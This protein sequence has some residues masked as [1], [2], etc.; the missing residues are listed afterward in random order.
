MPE[1]T[2]ELGKQVINAIEDLGKALGYYVHSEFPVEQRA[3]PPAVDVAWF[4]DEVEQKYPLMIFEVESLASNAMANNP[5]RVFGQ[6]SKEFERPL[7]FFHLVIKSGK[8][9]TR[10]ENLQR[11]FGAHNYRIYRLDD[12]FATSF[13]KDVL[14]QHRRIRRDIDLLITM[15]VLFDYDCLPADKEAILLHAIDL[16]LYGSHLS[17]L[18]WLSQKYSGA[19]KLF[20]NH[21]RR[22]TSRKIPKRLD[23]GY[24]SWLG[25]NWSTP[26]H[27]GLLHTSFPEDRARILNQL[28]WW[29]EQSSFMSQIG[30]HFGLSYDYDRFILGWSAGLWAIVAALM[31]EES[32][33]IKY[34]VEQILLVLKKI[35]YGDTT[36]WIHNA[37]W[38]LFISATLDDATFFEKIRQPINEKGGLPT[39]LF[40]S[41]MV[42]VDEEDED[43]NE[44]LSSPKQ[45]IPR[46]SS[47]REKCHLVAVIANELNVDRV[48]FALAALTTNEPFDLMGTVLVS[49]LAEKM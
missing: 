31:I 27:L 30:P 41:P 8:E 21:L 33:A 44:L 9:S 35:N 42:F 29:Q 19:K 20:L 25:S 26:I 11:V 5:T 49:F 37:T 18:A 13:V 45:L 12:G 10:V 24:D 36:D 38:G 48:D 34:I 16:G 23:T 46:H 40:T 3:R 7:F 6:A 14:S 39:K 2:K 32:F 47:F 4:A 1:H 17:N 15:S 43:W 22:E 28:K